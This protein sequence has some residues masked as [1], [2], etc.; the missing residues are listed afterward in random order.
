MCG[1]NG[2][3]SLLFRL[4]IALILCPVAS[5]GAGENILT[6]PGFEDSGLLAPF[7]A[8]QDNSR[9]AEVDVRYDRTIGRG[10][11][12][13]A[14]HIVA[15]RYR[16]GATQ[17]VQKG[18]AIQKGQTYVASIW[19]RGRLSQPVSILLREHGKPYRILVGRSFR[20]SNEWREYRFK[21]V[22]TGESSDAY[23]MVK[24]EGDG[25]L[26][27]D[28]AELTEDRD[29]GVM[30]STT[31]LPVAEDNLIVNGGFEVGVG[32][33]GVLYREAGSPVMVSAIEYQNPKPVLEVDGAFEGRQVMR[34]DVPKGASVTVSSAYVRA[35]PG[36][37]YTLRIRLRADHRHKVRIGV[38]HG[39]F[40]DQR[41]PSVPVVV[42]TQ[43]KTYDL[44][45]RLPQAVG[46]A[47]FVYVQSAEAGVLWVDAVEFAQG[48]KRA[49]RPAAPVEVGLRREGLSA[50]VEVGAAS[51]LGLTV[52]AY[53]S[54]T[55][56]LTL[57]LYDY[58]GR[59]HE[60]LTE[61]LNLDAGGRWSSE[62]AV[63]TKQPGYFRVL[64]EVFVDGVRV[65]A[66]EFALVVVPRP[67][68]PGADSPFGNHARFNDESLRLAQQLG[69]SW[70]RLHPPRTT[71]WYSIEP[72]AG[73]F[74]F[75]DTAI[76]DAKRRGFQILGSLDG[77]PRWISTAPQNVT[78]HN[79]SGYT[80]YVPADYER[81]REYV[82]RTVKHYRGVIDYWEVWNEPSSHTFLKLPDG[83]GMKARADAYMKLLRIAYEAAKEANPNTKIVA[84]CS[85]TIPPADWFEL[86]FERG[87][88]DLMD[89]AS[90][91]LY[92]GDAPSG[93]AGIS[94]A[95]SV[96][97]LKALMEHQD[98]S[99]PPKPIWQTEV[100]IRHPGTMYETRVNAYVEA[101]LT[102]VEGAEYIVKRHIDVLAAGI[103]KWFYYD[104]FWSERPDRQDYIGL[105][106]WD[107]AAR[108]ATA[109]Y[110]VLT[111]MLYG[112]KFEAEVSG[113]GDQ[114]IIAKF[115]GGGHMVYVAWSTGGGQK[116]AIPLAGDER[117]AAVYDIMG[118]AVGQPSATNVPHIDVGVS[119]RYVVVEKNER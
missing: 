61:T 36:Q 43:W 109:A 102:G 115:S 25:E 74:Q 63:P 34:V 59:R 16:R 20:V 68:I 99:R 117:I 85:T 11:A 84:G 112:L 69:V 103:E 94:T 10:D 50:I 42:N 96:R 49:Y 48:H 55:A 1:L 118:R 57:A 30:L 106:E 12:G 38:G 7:G 4:G 64:A 46:D 40:G 52:A 93:P 81:W 2:W 88:Y 65:D 53:V 73:N 9:W 26:W 70:L 3:F 87:A 108:P 83:G 116:V 27:L 56:T 113:G 54:R 6:N 22:A 110:A 86:L 13:S 28:D 39:I 21:A 92:Q 97:Q 33:W 31:A 79:N 75:F 100:G 105:F 35:V 89:I 114:I 5:A 14:V 67:V 24:F 91:H 72:E 44:P 23:F 95:E 32:R 107:G 8:W 66:D 47:Y 76:M 41:P 17:F 111:H 37:E 45:I 29:T 62:V 77:V 19:M 80:A 82:Y 18:I 15:S 104:M 58:E 78:V 90:I 60:V 101:P 119:P 71:K 98:S 51:S